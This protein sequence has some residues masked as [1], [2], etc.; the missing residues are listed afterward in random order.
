MQTPYMI[1]LGL[2]HSE[3]W[4]KT[5]AKESVAIVKLV[6]VNV[7]RKSFLFPFE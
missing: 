1:H 5:R 6:A 7:R 3:Q 2:V 4:L